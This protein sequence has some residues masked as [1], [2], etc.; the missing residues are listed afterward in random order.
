[1]AIALVSV[2]PGC[3]R[4]R[5]QTPGH[6]AVRSAALRSS[7]DGAVLDLDLDCVLSGPM[8]DALDHGIP[9]TLDIDLR[10]GGVSGGGPRAQAHDRVVLRY[11]PLSQRYQLQVPQQSGG[12][13][14]FAV[15]AYLIDALASLRLDL[16]AAFATLPRDTRLQ[17]A[18]GLDRAALPGALRLPAWFEPAWRLSTDYAWSNAG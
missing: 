12:S 11:Y 9:L 1:M 14:S 18:I 17:V 4:L 10:A 13:R 3:T 8:R 15:S 7:P 16:P 2:L 6:L 5:E